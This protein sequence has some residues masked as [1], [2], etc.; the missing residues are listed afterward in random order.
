MRKCC[1]CKRQLSL[2]NF[3]R[4][5]NGLQYRCK[6]CQ[7]TYRKSHY[8]NNKDKYLFKAKNQ[9]IKCLEENKQNIFDYKSKRGCLLCPEKEPCCLDFHHTSDDKE[10]TISSKVRSYTWN[11]LL[12]EIEKCVVICANCHRKIHAGKLSL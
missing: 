8:E 4:K 1:A 3:S 2:S 5:G 7:K 6:E 9:H 10:F 11:S 12:R